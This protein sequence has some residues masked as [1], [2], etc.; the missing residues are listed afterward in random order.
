MTTA[1]EPS[2]EV[3]Y[4][5]GYAAGM[6]TSRY[7]SLR[8]SATDSVLTQGAPSE[9]PATVYRILEVL[10]RATIDNHLSQVGWKSLDCLLLRDTLQELDAALVSFPGLHFH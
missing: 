1:S 5:G 7:Y 3:I 4:S 6:L 10:P 2:A 8:Y 9:L